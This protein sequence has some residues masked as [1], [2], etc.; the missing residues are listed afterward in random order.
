MNGYPMTC[1]V[2]KSPNDVQPA[3]VAYKEHRPV[4]GPNSDGS[5]NVVNRRHVGQCEEHVAP[6]RQ[7]ATEHLVVAQL[8]EAVSVALHALVALRILPIA[9]L[10]GCGILGRGHGRGS[11]LVWRLH[12]FDIVEWNV[13]FA[14]GGRVVQSTGRRRRGGRRRRWRHVKNRERWPIDSWK[15]HSWHEYV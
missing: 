2:S 11:V 14:R 4:V 6:E 12:L 5:H 15:N 3:G 10:C 9:T 7:W 13:P 1:T 8:L